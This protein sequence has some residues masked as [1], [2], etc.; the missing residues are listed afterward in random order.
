M[1]ALRWLE[2]QQALETR[3][4]INH[5]NQYAH[6]LL[7]PLPELPAIRSRLAAL[8]RRDIQGAPPAR[9]P[10]LHAAAWRGRSAADPLLRD[11]RDGTDA[12]LLDPRPLSAD[13][14]TSLSLEDIAMNGRVLVYGVRTG[15][16]D[17][18]ELRVKDVDTRQDLPDRLPRALYR[19]VTLQPDGKAFYYARQ[20]RATGIRIHRHVLGTPTDRDVEV[21]GDG[22]GPSDWIDARVSENGRHLV[23][24]VAHGWASTEA[25]VQWSSKRALCQRLPFDPATLRP[26]DSRVVPVVRGI[27]A[28]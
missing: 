27:D 14:T 11:R 24:T 7:D 4:F 10:L 8:M 6:S 1:D 12:I 3:A 2:D 21:F 9:R 25:Y 15:G 18:T 28:M 20:D 13:H 16:E 17:E 5:Q 26:F 19:G 22:F 23:F